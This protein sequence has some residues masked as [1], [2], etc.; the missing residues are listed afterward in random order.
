M[1]SPDLEEQASDSKWV[2]PSQAIRIAAYFGERLVALS[3]LEEA[4]FMMFNQENTL[5]SS[6]YIVA[7]LPSLSA[8]LLTA[9]PV[10]AWVATC[11]GM[12]ADMTTV[13]PRA[14]IYDLLGMNEDGQV[15][16]KAALTDLA[17]PQVDAAASQSMS[18]G[19]ALYHYL[20]KWPAKLVFGYVLPSLGMLFGGAAQAFGLGLR[21]T[22]SKA[23]VCAATTTTG[24]SYYAA[25]SWNDTSLTIQAL[26]GRFKDTPPARLWKM[27]KSTSLHANLDFLV[28]L[29]YRTMAWSFLGTAFATFSGLDKIAPWK[30]FFQVLAG[31]G[32][33]AFSVSRLNSANVEYLKPY[34][35]NDGSEGY[36]CAPDAE[37]T[38]FNPNKIT[39]EERQQVFGNMPWHQR[40]GYSVKPALNALFRA[41]GPVY[42]ILSRM[43]SMGVAGAAGGGALS[44]LAFALVSCWTLYEEFK[45]MLNVRVAN[46]NEPPM[47]RAEK[48][49]FAYMILTNVPNQFCRAITLPL[50]L[51]QAFPKMDNL[52]TVVLGLWMGWSYGLINFRYFSGALLEVAPDFK[53]TFM[54]EARL[55]KSLAYDLPKGV[56]YDGPRYIAG[57]LAARAGI[58]QSAVSDTN[59]TGSTGTNEQT[60][61]L[62]A[63]REGNPVSAKK[64]TGGFSSFFCCRPDGNQGDSASTAFDN[65]GSA[66][67]EPYYGAHGIILGGAPGETSNV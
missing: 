56:L 11:L 16:E 28:M 66:V 20:I 44:L 35:Q 42:F 27:S 24:F 9:R 22:W 5:E 38:K 37:L 30:T 2:D 61:L 12:L 15:A 48:I 45:H 31:M 18:F 40:A 43:T 53:N 10:G 41:S 46:K 26:A 59:G 47:T 3:L 25:W 57:R 51:N 39:S 4:L 32:G 8:V 19:Q 36:A 21:S 60:P 55:V 54:S 50:F 52:D 34:R 58:S 63:Q 29:F 33:A 65:S 64:V 14:E 17:N 67:S 7:T 23:L 13:R 6:R 49:A 62:G 1:P